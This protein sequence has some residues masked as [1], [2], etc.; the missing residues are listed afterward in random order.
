MNEM[1]TV[2]RTR[3]HSL[4]DDLTSATPGASSHADSARA[5]FRRRRRARAGLAVA[6]AAV[7]A[8]VVAVPVIGSLSSPAPG[9]DGAAPGPTTSASP[10][11]TASEASAQRQAEQAATA[12]RLHT[13]ADD[14]RNTLAGREAPLSFEGPTAGGS[15][16]DRAPTVT[17]ALGLVPAEHSSGAAQADCVW[18]TPAGDLQVA[19]GFMTGGTVDQIHA[20]VDAETARGDCLPTALP[21]SLTFAALALC[22]EDGGTG[23][24]I[25]VMDTSGTGFW[26]LSVTVG[27]QRPQDEV[28][29]V[30]AVLDAAD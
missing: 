15:C 29:T 28:F 18:R 27:D 9:R 26:L 3:L 14:P 2:L 24:H 22:A 13:L 17:S 11:S 6:S 20:D 12:A 5:R 1:D 30:A 23:W 19:I 10:S 21:W 16:P 8:A 7:A 4:A 25:R